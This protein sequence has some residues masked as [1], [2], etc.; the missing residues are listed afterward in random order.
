MSRKVKISAV[1]TALIL[2]LGMFGF[3]KLSNQKKSTISDAPSKVSIRSVKVSNLISTDLP[4]EINIDGR[5]VPYEKVDLFSKVSA[6]IEQSSKPFKEGTYYTKGELI[7]RLDDQEAK[8]TLLSQRSVLLN[9]ITQ[10]MPDLKFD[11]PQAFEKW[12]NYLLSFD[13]EKTTAPLP[14]VSNNQEKFFV[15]SKSIYNQYYNIKSLETRMKEY[16]IKAPISGVLTEANAYTGML[17]GPS[18]KLGT[19]INSNEFELEAP[20]SLSDLNYISIGQHVKL[21]T[22][23]STQSWDGIVKRI[24]NK[25]DEKTQYVPI[26]IH[27]KGKELK[28]GLY[29]SGIVHG[30][31]LANVV[32]IDK[33]YMPSQNTVYVVKDSVLTT[34]AI[35]IYKNSSKTVYT[36][37]IKPDQMV[38]TDVISG[39]YEG[40]KVKATLVK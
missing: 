38:V 16:Y 24:G 1:A 2:L 10:I 34:Q 7:F 14:L 21:A 19:I 20:I 12:Q 35:D 23:S 17:I 8:F 28:E 6:Q 31:K 4:N 18:T 11:Y 40:Q 27:V 13:L 5:L 39:L 26:Y 37:S 3:H 29:L 9:S 15:A 33:E 30:K 25:I 32:A 36:R 22:N